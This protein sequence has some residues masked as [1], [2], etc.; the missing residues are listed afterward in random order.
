MAEQAP[1]E[2]ISLTMTH[3]EAADYMLEEEKE[4]HTAKD[5]SVDISLSEEGLESKEN[6]EKH[7]RCG[8]F[9]FS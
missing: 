4:D 5:E 2:D 9:G 3:I 6:P 7:Q 8:L 1:V